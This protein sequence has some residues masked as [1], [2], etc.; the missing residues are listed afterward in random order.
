MIKITESSIQLL[1]EKFK[2]DKEAIMLIKDCLLS[3]SKYHASIYRME[4]YMKLFGYG[5]T[6]KE[7]YQQEVISLDND[8]TSSHNRVI[9]SISIFNRLCEKKDIPLIYDGVVSEEKPYR[10][11]IADACLEYISAIIQ[12]RQ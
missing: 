8:R 5:N 7:D 6:D 3:F 9:S 4:T 1:I 10:R 2:D 11:E 12:K